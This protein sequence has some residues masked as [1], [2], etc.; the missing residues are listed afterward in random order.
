[1]LL[2]TE[3]SCQV[4]DN[5]K[6]RCAAAP[7]LILKPYRFG[8][9]EGGWPDMPKHSVKDIGPVRP[10]GRVCGVTPLREA[11]PLISRGLTSRLHFALGCSIPPKACR[12][13]QRVR[14]R[15][16]Q[17]LPGPSRSPPTT[18]LT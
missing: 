11:I 5:G 10:S 1:M 13:G 9:D 15:F 17:H 7:P 18:S 12:G 3:L 6:F 14:A 16:R 2:M 8:L 4:M